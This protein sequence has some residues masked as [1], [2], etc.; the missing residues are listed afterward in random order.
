M[1]ASALSLLSGEA[2]RNMFASG[3]F[4]ISNVYFWLL[5][6]VMKLFG[7]GVAEARLLGAVAGWLTLVV[8]VAIAYRNF[9]HRMALLTAVL[10]SALGV[11]L[12]FSRETTEATPT[13]LCW[14]LSVA[15]L[16]E[17]GRRGG[18]W[19]WVAAGIAGALSLYF[20]P[21]GRLWLVLAALVCPYL[22]VRA[23]STY[24]RA[25][26][27]GTTATA[28]AALLTLGPFLANAAVN[29]D[30]VF[31]RAGQVSVFSEE[32]AARLP[33]YDPGWST[34]QL[35]WEQLRHSLAIFASTGD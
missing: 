32:N 28:L 35:V 27:A 1:P 9:G 26:L 10:G 11:M 17:A 24:R 33:Y 19:P 5:A 14:A 21:S 6:G 25:A 22:V 15:F 13:A 31:R 18:T 16:L 23:G 4:Y 20:Y 29:P 8:V 3:W 2:P 7:V 12:Q 30:E 34:V